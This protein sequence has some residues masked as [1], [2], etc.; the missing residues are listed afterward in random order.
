MKTS[1]GGTHLKNKRKTRRPLDFKKSTHLVLRLREHLP[2]LLSPRDRVLRR[3]FFRIAEKYGVRVY[4]LVF[5]H[6]H[7]HAVILIPNRGAYLGFIK[8]VT[9]G[10]VRHF[11]QVV[12]IQ[13]KKIFE[14][15]PFTRI[16]GWGRAALILDKY[17]VKNEKESGVKQLDPKTG[18]KAK[19]E[20]IPILQIRAGCSK[21]SPRQLEF[22]IL[23]IS[24]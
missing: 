15:R 16:V 14:G 4:K 1:F 17:M 7:L 11:S 21:L 2:S 13:L 10:F 9:S 18:R 3:G 6:S 5:N 19:G 8:E 23:R 24:P 12:R 20:K 22:E